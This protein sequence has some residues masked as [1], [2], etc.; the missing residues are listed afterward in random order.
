MKFFIPLGFKYEHYW[1]LGNI[2]GPYK[3][4]KAV[5]EE[6]ARRWPNSDKT[7]QF[8]ILDGKVI[9]VKPSPKKNPE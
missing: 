9:D 1:H 7:E 6:I 5:K 8:L 4:D 2:Y 3:N